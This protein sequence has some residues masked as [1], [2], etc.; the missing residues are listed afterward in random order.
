M[1]FGRSV[2]GSEHPGWESKLFNQRRPIH[3]WKFCVQFGSGPCFPFHSGVRFS[4]GMYQGDD[5]QNRGFCFLP[6]QFA[7]DP[8][9]VSQGPGK[10]VPRAWPG[11]KQFRISM[12]TPVENHLM[13]IESFNRQFQI[14]EKESCYAMRHAPCVMRFSFLEWFSLKDYLQRPVTGSRR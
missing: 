10:G 3:P 13:T 9:G 1:P 5:P 4:L 2:H 8:W 11:K 14:G 12:Q 7:E 6:A